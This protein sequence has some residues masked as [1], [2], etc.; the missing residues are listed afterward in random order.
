MDKY[1][2]VNSKFLLSDDHHVMTQ[3]GML[4]SS[5][6][7]IGDHILTEH[8]YATICDIV[9]CGKRPNAQIIG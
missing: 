9:K 3:R 1:I 7:Q 8:E 5:E 6:L 2:K 4:K